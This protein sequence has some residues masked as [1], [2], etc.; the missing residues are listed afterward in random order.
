MTE[1]TERYILLSANKAE[2]NE[3]P[4]KVVKFKA[5]R[6]TGITYEETD[7]G[8]EKNIKEW[9]SVKIP[10]KGHF[11][12]LES[13]RVRLAISVD[14]EAIPVDAAIEMEEN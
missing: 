4:M 5:Y 7:C 8:I 9:Y 12:K 3:E 11:D 10:K 6:N 1:K 14:V 2:R 13:K